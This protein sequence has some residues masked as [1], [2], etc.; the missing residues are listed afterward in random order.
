MKIIVNQEEHSSL[1]HED[2]DA[3]VKL[4]QKQGI[5]DVMLVVQSSL[6]GTTLQGSNSNTF[7]KETLL[8]NLTQ[9]QGDAL[10]LE[11]N[12]N[13]LRERN[14]YLEEKVNWLR[15][16]AQ[17][18]D[19]EEVFASINSKGRSY[20]T[21]NLVRVNSA[22]VQVINKLESKAS[23]TDRKAGVL[24]RKAK[25]TS[26]DNALVAN[27]EYFDY[28]YVVS[29]LQNLG[30]NVKNPLGFFMAFGAE[31]EISPSERFDTKA[32]LSMNP[33]VKNSG[34]N[35]LLHYLKHGKKEGRVL[36]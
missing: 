24:F 13:Q 23:Y 10:A 17:N 8:Y 20:S 7:S 9:L 21:A 6:E 2:L 18:N 35:P 28:E 27:S 5:I 14:D 16:K 26:A 1:S 36:I 25:R 32:Y 11:E 29:E 22:L 34:M 12:V 31:L 3:I 4:I 15:G 30:L 19:N 33:D